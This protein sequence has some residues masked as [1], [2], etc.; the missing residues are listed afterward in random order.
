ME[1]EDL[2]P[3]PPHEIGPTWRRKRDGGWW[4]PERNRTIGDQVINFLYEY[5][6]QPSGP[7][8]GQPFLP[9]K[10]QARFIMWWYAVDEQGRFVYRQGMLRRLK[11]WGKDPLAAA[12]ALA[13]L[14]G[15]VDAYFEDG[16]AVKTINR[17]LP[18][19]MLEP[20]FREFL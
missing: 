18:T 4:L 20:E 19:P 11:G 8:A 15:P 5:V 16:E 14:C 13:E 7:R 3:Q 6:T 10:E 12:L 2:L 17:A 1:E 9:T